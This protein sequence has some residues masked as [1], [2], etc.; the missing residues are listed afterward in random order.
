MKKSVED[1]LIIGVD[2]SE[3][4]K[5]VLYVI[6]IKGNDVYVIN[7]FE[8]EEAREVYNKLIGVKNE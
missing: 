6:K 3:N 7:Q 1:R 8:N 4:D 2:F 5:D